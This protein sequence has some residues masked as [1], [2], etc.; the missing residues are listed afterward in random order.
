MKI[1]PTGFEATTRYGR[2]LTWNVDQSYVDEKRIHAKM[3]IANYAL[4]L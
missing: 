3:V 1:F 4:I 2:K